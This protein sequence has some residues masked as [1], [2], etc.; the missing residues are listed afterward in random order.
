MISSKKI[1]LSG[2]GG[3]PRV[4]S[5]VL[6][7]ADL[8]Q[9]ATQEGTLIMRGQGRSYGDA[10]ISGTGTVVM[11]EY[12]SQLSQIDDE[13]LIRAAA[14]ATLDQV[15]KIAVPNGW[16]PAVVPG[17]R[18]VSIGGCLAA[19][20]H[21]K[22][23]HRVGSFVEHV[24]E[25]ELLLADETLVRCSPNENADLFW[26]TAGGMGLTGVITALTIQLIRVQSPYMC[27]RYQQSPNLEATLAML[28]DKSLDDEYTVM[29]LDCAARGRKLGR[30]VLLRGHH[31]TM[32]EVP[33][34]L[35][36]AENHSQRTYALAFNFP[37]W[38]LNSHSISAFNE[39]YYRSHGAKKLLVQ[40]YQDFFFPL[41]RIKHWNRLYGRRGFIQYQCVFPL[42][43]SAQA[44]QL[45][46]EKLQ[47]SG[48][49]SFLS[50]LKLF[51]PGNKSPISFPLEG[52]TLTLDM[53]L[54]D[55][56][57]FTFLDQLDDLV[58][59][60]GG[61]V[62]LAKDARMNA[63]RFRRMY[64]RVAEWKAIKS[65]VDP[66]NHFQSDLSRRLELSSNGN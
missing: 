45:V 40:H 34:K 35:R 21:G 4:E 59:R 27:V 24:S 33:A 18:Y 22:N 64:S 36:K 57:L 58:L 46:L 25:F 7:P 47:Q 48:Y 61:R 65:R 32:E 19:D 53:P 55:P 66:G 9:I 11:S 54:G 23:H 56:A 8:S 42:A 50:V 1:E 6:T 63:E 13:G 2:W 16:F 14:G 38:I 30:S 52:Y 41:D 49:A 26:A 51:G 37:N 3:Y 62:Y 31:A 12:L 44:L 60:F 17:T 15:L 10:A 39:F 5:H 28:S 43:A 20:V 29:W